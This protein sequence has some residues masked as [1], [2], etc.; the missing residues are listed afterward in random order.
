[1][2]NCLRFQY[3][4]GKE[5]RYSF[6]V[7]IKDLLH[8][9]GGDRGEGGHVAKMCHFLCNH[10][11]THNRLGHEDKHTDTHGIPRA[12]ASARGA[13]GARGAQFEEFTL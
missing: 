11:H 12:P 8:N 1:M 7:W 5:S 4:L 10:T 3:I 9:T 13:S 6:V 2:T